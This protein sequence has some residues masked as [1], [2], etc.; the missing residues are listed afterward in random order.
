MTQT[1]PVHLD[2]V[3]TL[4][5]GQS[6]SNKHVV[7]SVPYCKDVPTDP[8]NV[9]TGVAL[10]ASMAILNLCC[11]RRRLNR[12]WRDTSFVIE[13]SLAEYHMCHNVKSYITTNTEIYD[14]RIYADIAYTLWNFSIITF[15]EAKRLLRFFCES[16]YYVVKILIINGTF[17]I[18]KIPE[19]IV[20]MNA[21][22]L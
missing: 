7:I 13:D 20:V 21:T 12:Y 22:F 11:S 15:L 19:K 17:K 3:P 9:N 5:W 16:V 8:G 14:T 2:V 10:A 6:D 4:I 18:S 1:W